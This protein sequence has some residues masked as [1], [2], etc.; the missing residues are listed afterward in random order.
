MNITLKPD[1]KP[2]ELRPYQLNPKYNEKVRK[3][4]EKILEVEIIELVEE[5]NYVSPVVVQ[6]KKKQ[7]EIRICVDLRNL[8]NA[9]VHDPFQLQLQMKS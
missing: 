9:C 4:L 2:M 3:E 1:A 7:D 5:S 8:N 6:E